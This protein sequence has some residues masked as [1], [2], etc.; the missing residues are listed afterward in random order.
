M[1]KDL[2]KNF[3]WVNM[4]NQVVENVAKC[5]TCQRVKAEHQRPSG[6]LQ[7]LAIPEWKWEKVTMD[8]VTDLPRTRSGH[9]SIWVIVDRLTKYAHF[10]PI[11]NTTS[12]Q[13]LAQL[14]IR[15]VVR[16]HGVPGWDSHLPL[17]E[18]AYNNS[19]QA[20]IG[21]A[22][23]EALYGRKC[24]S[25]ERIR[26]AQSRQKSY[27]DNRRRD[28]EFEV[29]DRVFLRL[30]PRRVLYDLEKVEKYNP[31]LTHIIKE[32]IPVIQEDLSYVEQPL[33]IID[34]QIKELRGKRIPLVKVLWQKHNK[35]E[36]ATWELEEDMIK[37]YPEIFQEGI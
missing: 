29:G 36:D 8:F 4:K 12:L 3:W 2:K 5:L 18:F 23:Y 19:Y 30:S 7:P 22:P 14:Y 21:M 32:E 33:R 26:I 16:L 20:T 27:A 15:E 1:Y 13:R 11:R 10:L 9:D 17:A 31:D 34:H 6:L 28:L 24:R 35:P 37:N 25:P